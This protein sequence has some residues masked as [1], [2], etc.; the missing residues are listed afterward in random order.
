MATRAVRSSVGCRL[1]RLMEMPQQAVQP[2]AEV[3]LAEFAFKLLGFL[4]L[5]LA[6]REKAVG[7]AAQ[8]S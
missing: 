2:V 7:A 1:Q 8:S 5:E 3:A 6:Q 4:Q